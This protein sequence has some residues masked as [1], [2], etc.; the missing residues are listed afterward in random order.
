MGRRA[1]SNSTPPGPG[2][3]PGTLH[4]GGGVA[5]NVPQGGGNPF[6][7]PSLS[8]VKGRPRPTVRVEAPPPVAPFFPTGP[9]PRSPLW[10]RPSCLRPSPGSLRS[11]LRG[12]LT[13]SGL[14]RRRCPRPAPTAPPARSRALSGTFRARAAAVPGL[15]GTVAGTGAAAG[16]GGG[17]GPGAAALQSGPT[18]CQVGGDRAARAMPAGTSPVAGAR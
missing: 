4:D 3:G 11:F 18:P 12:V 16:A 6:R 14:S 15:A 17:R 9:A 10:T 7:A 8:L 1:G 2:W 5:R 13:R